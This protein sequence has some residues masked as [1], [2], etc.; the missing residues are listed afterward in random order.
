MENEVNWRYVPFKCETAA[1]NMATD[2][3]LFQKLIDNDLGA[4]NTIRFYSW[5]PSAA[6]IGTNQSL[7]TEIDTTF[8][9][10]NNIDVVRRI[11]GGGAVFHDGAGEI[12]YSVICR[13]GEL[14]KPKSPIIQFEKSI[15][16]SYRSILEALGEGLRCLGVSIDAKKIHCPALLSN[17]KKISGNAQKISKGVLLQHG[18]I[19][20]SIQPD[21]MYSVLRPP[22]GVPKKKIVHSVRAK[23]TGISNLMP[24]NDTNTIIEYLIDGFKTKWGISFTAED[25]SEKECDEINELM[26][27]RYG[28]SK[29]TEK[30][31]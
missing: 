10:Q 17:G 5:K 6:S 11:T 1:E 25:I 24:L 7:H 19:L 3:F 8:A 27:N 22:E 13:L 18:T 2:E 16:Q 26:K 21:I 23:V 29:W 28:N 12:T 9:K 31:I 20:L 4:K 14:P 30:I 15:T